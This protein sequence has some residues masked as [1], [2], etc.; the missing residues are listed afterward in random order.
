MEDPEWVLGLLVGHLRRFTAYGGTIG[1]ARVLELGP[2]RSLGQLFFFH[3]LGADR[4]LGV[5]VRRYATEE[6]G[7]GVYRSILEHLADWVE[8]GRFPISVDAEEALARGREILPDGA[9]FPRLGDRLDYAILRD[10]SLPLPSSSIDLAYS[11][12]VL[13]HVSDPASVYRELARVL[14]EGGLMSHIIDLRDHH[15][16]EP[17]DFLRYS[18]RLWSLM[19]GRSAGF[20]NRLRAS[21]HLRLIREAGFEV[22]EVEHRRAESPPPPALLAR[23]F[24]AYDPE[25]LRTLV[26]TVTAR[27][28]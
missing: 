2:G 9:G 6:S 25:D 15:R 23:R 18:D 16:P 24:R 28:P 17:L 19:Q 5:D 26:L 4:A 14:R 8:T 11:C 20:T 3:L 1:G 12:S 21:D 22:L 27:R 10:R 13:E 7:A